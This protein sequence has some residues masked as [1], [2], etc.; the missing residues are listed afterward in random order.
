MN[1]SNAAVHSLSA[2]IERD[3]CPPTDSSS[4]AS[5]ADPQQVQLSKLI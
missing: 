1:A 2:R 5:V 4:A 3:K